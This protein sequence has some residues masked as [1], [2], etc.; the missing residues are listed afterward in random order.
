MIDRSDEN[1][2]NRTSK[3]YRENIFTYHR[4][5]GGI[6]STAPNPTI[7]SGFLTVWHAF[8]VAYYDR[9]GGPGGRFCCDSAYDVPIAER[10]TTSSVADKLTPI[11]IAVI[12]AICLLHLITKHSTN[13]YTVVNS[14][15]RWD[16]RL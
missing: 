6:R 13:K 7:Q 12:L 2:S 8:S 4:N 3:K 15:T 10:T 16:Q 1:Y 11:A 14:H 5:A 9:G